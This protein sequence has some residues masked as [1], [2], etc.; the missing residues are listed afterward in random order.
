[1]GKER[2]IVAWDDVSAF[3]NALPNGQSYHP[4]QRIGAYA[5]VEAGDVILET[6][7]PLS[8]AQLETVISSS[9]T[10]FERK[11]L[12]LALAP[13][14]EDAAHDGE[15]ALTGA[16]AGDADFPGWEKLE[17]P[18][19]SVVPQEWEDDPGQPPLADG[20]L[21][22]GH[23]LR[24]S[25]FTTS[26]PLS[27]RMTDDI[28]LTVILIDGG[29][30]AFQFSEQDEEVIAEATLK[31]AA[32]L[33]GQAPKKDITFASSLIRAQ[34]SLDHQ[35][36]GVTPVALENMWRD[37]AM[38]SLGYAGPSFPA[39]TQLCKDVRD[40]T[41]SNWSYAA[42][43]TKF[44]PRPHPAYAHMGFSHLV[45]GYSA[46]MLNMERLLIHET[47]HIFGAPDEYASQCKGG[48]AWGYYGAP[49]S[50][51]KGS[52]GDEGN[53]CIMR[54]STWILCDATKAHV[55]FRGAEPKDGGDLIG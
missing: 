53:G 17:G 19:L 13:D 44:K 18:F 11:M 6:V 40:D 54:D 45:I 48:G 33:Y 27:A 23:S 52:P 9:A 31:A 26:N 41:G 4:Q 55:G 39:V 3:R 10:A 7:Q 32:F 20:E 22:V 16:A 50:N 34:V 29:A 8:S 46:D 25:G 49:N 43:F 12:Q 21:V 38:A 14:P 15:A 30:P 2:K 36:E 35:P 51:C 1:M 42:F 28:A 24:S 5:V 37:E 47:C